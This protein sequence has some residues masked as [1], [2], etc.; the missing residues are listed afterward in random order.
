MAEDNSAESVEQPPNA[1]T[2]ERCCRRNGGA[3][4]AAREWKGSPAPPPQ[5][6]G[7]SSTLRTNQGRGDERDATASGA[8]ERGDGFSRREEGADSHS[9]RAAETGGALSDDN[10]NLLTFYS[11]STAGVSGAE[12]ARA[13]GEVTARPQRGA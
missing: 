10:A 8:G 6:P 4:Q 2:L 12:E 11:R 7:R 3:R 9:T 1:R 5:T 13:A